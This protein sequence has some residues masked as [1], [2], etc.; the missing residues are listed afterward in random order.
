MTDA[1]IAIFHP[2]N[3]ALAP[4]PAL[5]DPF[6]YEPHPLAR[7]AADEVRAYIAGQEAWAEELLAGKMF[8][9]LVCSD[10][11]GQTGFLAAYSGQIGGRA[12]WPWFVPAVFDYL[13]PDGYFKQEE[14]RITAINRQIEN[15]QATP[16]QIE[17]LRQER[18]QR[19]IALQS[20]L[21]DQ[22]RML[23]ANGEERSLTDIFRETPQHVPPSGA[24]ECC[25]PKLL[26]YA[27]QHCLK[28]RFIA[29]FWVGRSPKAEIRHDG[30]FYTACRGRCKPILE[31][32]LQPDY[33]GAR[34]KAAQAGPL[35]TIYEDAS[36][37]VIVKPAGMLSVPG[38]IEG[39]S[40]ASVLRER[41]PYVR[42][43]MIVHRLDMDTSGLMVVALVPEA[44]H[45]LQQQ[46][47]A[48]TIY[49]RYTALLDGPLPEWLPRCGTINLPMRP[50]HLDRP[51]Q[52]IDFIYGKTAVTDYELAESTVSRVF[53]TPHTGRTH[54]LRVH[55]AHRDGLGV[56]IKG[57][58]LYGTAA[59]RLY[60]H[61]DKL[62]FVHPI[63]Q[64]TMTF[65]APAPF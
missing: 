2:L 1:G 28:P 26:Q 38:K 9:V 52:I 32:M 25:A 55:C 41:Y 40:V 46:F 36:L 39:P 7:L 47:L 35:T 3:T 8:G 18:R 11:D 12:D 17:S 19:S 33:A 21:F 65:S 54:Q 61:A 22:F 34:T 27:Y 10:R 62:T 56:P 53:L 45:H 14:A 23:N 24:G 31:W 42:G 49:K 64:Q 29:E 59:D 60:L 6:D 44:Y 57:D 15:Q 5:N 50:D 20:W 13:Q 63:T 37:M 30:H 51:R 48:R 4:P 58:P 16:Q 43:P